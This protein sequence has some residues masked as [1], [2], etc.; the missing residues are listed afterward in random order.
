MNQVST[1]ITSKQEDF[2]ESA[3]AKPFGTNVIAW[4][5]LAVVVTAVL[6]LKFFEL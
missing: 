3:Y 5:L 6:S 2:P 4:L 1:L